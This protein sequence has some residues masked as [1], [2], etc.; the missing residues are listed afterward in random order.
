MTRPVSL[1]PLDCK[2]SAESL[3]ER[4]ELQSYLAICDPDSVRRIQQ[5]MSALPLLFASDATQQHA[6]E[7]ATTVNETPF[8]DLHSSLK[9]L[10]STV[11]IFTWTSYEKKET[12]SNNP[13][14]NDR[15]S[16]YEV[17]QTSNRPCRSS[18]LRCVEIKPGARSASKALLRR[19]KLL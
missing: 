1:L 16:A 10:N 11:R 3:I 14:P 18:N 6:T 9:G 13:N 19:F 5:E 2:P 8:G 4:D 15:Y 7:A 17:W 12:N